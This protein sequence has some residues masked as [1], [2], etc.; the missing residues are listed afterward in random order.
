MINNHLLIT[1]TPHFMGFEKW[2]NWLVAIWIYLHID[3]SITCRKA[4]CVLNKVSRL[5]NN[6]R[7]TVIVFM[8]IKQKPGFFQKIVFLL[9]PFTYCIIYNFRLILVCCLLQEFELHILVLFHFTGNFMRKFLRVAGI[10]KNGN[11]P[12][13][14]H[15]GTLPAQHANHYSVQQQA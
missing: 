8:F 5:I 15:R 4:V 6:I 10:R 3:A 11:V 14:V 12:M 9:I 1:C 2:L 13:D 7:E